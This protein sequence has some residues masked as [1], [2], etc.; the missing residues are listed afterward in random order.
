M[1]VATYGDYLRRPTD[2]RVPDFVSAARRPLTGAEAVAWA[3]VLAAGRRPGPLIAGPDEPSTGHASA[4]MTMTFAVLGLGT[5]FN[6]I[7][8]RRDPASGLLPPI[9]K[10]VGISSITAALV[11]LGTELPEGARLREPRGGSCKRI[12]VGCLRTSRA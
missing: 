11:F 2:L 5:V 6:A 9:L 3:D 4:S 1:I 10:A 8:N 12:Q 7:V